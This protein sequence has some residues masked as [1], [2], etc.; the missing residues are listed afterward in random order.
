M[1]LINEAMMGELVAQAIASPRR[2]QHFNLHDSYEDPCQRL[3]NAMCDDTYIRPH[4]HLVDRKSETLVALTGDFGFVKF[5]ADGHVV[6][7]VR[8]AAGSGCSAVEISPSEWHMILCLTPTA[9]LLEAKGGPFDP[10]QAKEAA[11]WAP[12]EG[13]PAAFDYL[14]ALR[15]RFF[16]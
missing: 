14:N 11:P 3:L 2:R 16:C 9:V 1:R 5:D 12:A 15:A 8:L 4:R 7:A 13:D 10:E 6:C